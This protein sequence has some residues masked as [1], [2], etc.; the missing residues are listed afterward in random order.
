MLARGLVGTLRFPKPASLEYLVQR[1]D[2][3][4]IGNCEGR[5]GKVS[6]A[7]LESFSPY[8]KMR[9]SLADVAHR[10]SVPPDLE[11]D[12]SDSDVGMPQEIAYANGGLNQNMAH[13]DLGDVENMETQMVGPASEAPVQQTATEQL[14][15]STLRMFDPPVTLVAV[16]MSHHEIMSNNT[17]EATPA[18]EPS[19]ADAS[20]KPPKPTYKKPSKP[21]DASSTSNAAQ[22]HASNQSPNTVRVE[23]TAGS[24]KH[25]SSSKSASGS[26][27]PAKANDARSGPSY[28][29]SSSSMSNASQQGRVPAAQP[30]KSDKASYR[31]VSG[32]SDTSSG[33]MSFVQRERDK[34]ADKKPA[35]HGDAGVAYSA[36]VAK[37][38]SS[39]K[40]T[41]GV[42]VEPVTVSSL[43]TTL[44]S[45]DKKKGKGND[46]RSKETTVSVSSSPDS[47]PAL[48]VS[49]PYPATDIVL[50]SQTPVS[51]SSSMAI[52]YGDS[53]E[54]V[55][56][57]FNNPTPDRFPQ[58]PSSYGMGYS[59]RPYQH[60]Y[61][62]EHR[63][64]PTQPSSGRLTA[65]SYAQPPHNNHYN[66]R[67][68]GPVTGQ[69][70]S[71]PQYNPQHQPQTGAMTGYAAAPATALAAAP[72]QNFSAR[73]V[74]NFHGPTTV[75]VHNHHYP[76]GDGTGGG[77]N[78]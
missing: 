34:L 71:Q 78:R 15:E 69:A 43:K 21:S 65:Q 76:F 6:T 66:Q 1:L 50:S 61:D 16:P 28:S 68:S 41:R 51:P 62:L 38:T 29:P 22:S 64:S 36:N 18:A 59:P 7:H 30:K 67:L 73:D 19:R 75:T 42:G 70:Y 33:A 8:P 58:A 24:S 40:A 4:G 56:R 13:L 3:E 63:W 32:D 55:S 20:K 46:T 27:K 2:H 12:T 53:V 72:V 17:D 49:S 37:S 35:K 39:R 47:S 77:S 31:H 54:D 52:G 45:S 48:D 44:K 74:N 14:V 11:T 9:E 57:T 25:S 10:R 23:P 5:N 60:P 26:K